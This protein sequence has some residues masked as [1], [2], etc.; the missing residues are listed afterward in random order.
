[1]LR[2]LTCCAL[3]SIASVL[4]AGQTKPFEQTAD[5][6]KVFELTNKERKD[7]ELPALALSPALSKIARAHSENMAHQGKMEHKLDGKE[8][9]DRLRDAG[10]M[11]TKVAENIAEGEEGVELAK[12]MKAWMDSEGHRK[13]ILH[14]ECSEIGVGIARD[15][16]GTSYITQV[17]AK[18]RK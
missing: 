12:I 5:E 15:K 14:P 4:P 11:F 10:Y 6:T 8:A 3:A 16:A 2:I 1:M 18:P 7:K 13:N 17:F 9:V